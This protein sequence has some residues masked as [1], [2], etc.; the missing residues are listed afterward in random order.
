MANGYIKHRVT[1]GGSTLLMHNGQTA[2]P[3]NKYAKA[4]KT[5][6]SDRAL[7]KTDEGIEQLMRIE[8]EAGLYLD[9][10]K[11]VILQSRVLEAHLSEAARRT[12]E[13]KLALAGMFVDTDGVLEYD[14]GP[15][16][17]AEL[18]DSDDHRFTTGVGVNG[19][20]VMR[21]RPLFTNWKTTFEVSVLGEMAGSSSLRAW[22]ENGGNFIGIGDYR[23]RYGRYELKAFEV[24][25]EKKSLKAAA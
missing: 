11:R 20:T 14:G 7:K 24:L 19:S 10:K 16:S 4:M 6:T 8:Y 2:D 12:K 13:G 25:A 22:L 18:L 21:T 1:I 15:L 23:P 9:S 3:L 17:L 5:I